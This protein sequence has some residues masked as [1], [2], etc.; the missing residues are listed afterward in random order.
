MKI[1]L[2]LT[3]AAIATGF[4]ASEISAQ[5]QSSVSRDGV[6]GEALFKQRCAACHSVAPNGRSVGP[7]LFGVVGR[8]AASA[9]FNYSPA[10]KKSGLSWDATTLDRY[11]AAPTKTVPGT[12][13]IIS[14]PNASDRK[15]ILSFLEM[16]R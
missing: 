12:R 11:I 6:R 15:A 10:L 16:K 7:S 1:A 14:V 9:N 5:T 8:K 2:F 4:G 13:M 3:L